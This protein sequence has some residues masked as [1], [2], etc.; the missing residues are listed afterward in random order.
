M[1]KNYMFYF[2]YMVKN[3]KHYENTHHVEH[4]AHVEMDEWLDLSSGEIEQKPGIIIM[5]KK[6]E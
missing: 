3:I 4:V 2:N 5:E 1:Y 6:N